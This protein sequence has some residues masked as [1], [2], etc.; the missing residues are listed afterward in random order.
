MT[1]NSPEIKGTMPIHSFRH[2]VLL[3]VQ[4]ILVIERFGIDFHLLTKLHLEFTSFNFFPI[5]KHEIILS[6]YFSDHITEVMPNR[7][8]ID[9]I[10]L[11]NLYK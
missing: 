9:Y 5:S 6:E 4:L 1:L 10:T 8:K 11:T 7:P 3:F 2:V